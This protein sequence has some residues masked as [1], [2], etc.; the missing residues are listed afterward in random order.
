MEDEMDEPES[1]E[2]DTNDVEI[3]IPLDKNNDPLDNSLPNPRIRSYPIYHRGPF[4]VF[5]KQ[6]QTS[7]SFVA[8][9]RKLNE[10]FKHCVKNIMKM[11]STKMRVELD[12]ATNA[13]KILKLPFLQE[14][15]VYIP[16]ESVEIDGIVSISQDVEPDEIVAM[17]KGKFSH[18]GIPMVSV[19]HAHRYSKRIEGDNFETL[20]TVRISFSGT[21]LPKW[22][23]IYNVLFPVRMY[24]PQLMHCKK[25]LGDHHTEKHC[26]SKNICRKCKGSHLT[27]VCPEKT[28][29][30]PHCREKIAHQ[31]NDE[32]P[33]FATKTQKLISKTR[34]RS[35]QSYAA[36]VK[37]CPMVPLQNQY[38]SL[39]EDSEDPDEGNTEEGCSFWKNIAKSRRQTKYHNANLMQKSNFEAKKRPRSPSG[40]IEKNWESQV[41]KPK[42]KKRI[43]EKSHN[44]VDRKSSAKSD[45]S[46]VK[47]DTVKN[48]ISSL[49]GYFGVPSHAQSMILA[50]VFPLIDSWWPSICS[51][52][53]GKTGREVSSRIANQNV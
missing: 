28:P 48:I 12:S 6:K 36:A 51:S 30:C 35:K 40:E 38:A 50:I 15:R 34:K 45:L 49:M 19:N 42:T 27:S 8:I 16:A 43:T 4:V 52:M 22:L 20:D 13:N 23:C 10:N 47:V 53:S 5:I 37:S 33:A 7:I 18:P 14:Y 21:A 25:C 17:G 9:A 24:N 41:K 1:G 2:N 26:T 39:T 32:C 29:W 46:N 44:K 31:E 11:N 3:V